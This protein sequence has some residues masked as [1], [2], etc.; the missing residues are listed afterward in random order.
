MKI[1]YVFLSMLA[2]GMLAACSN[3]EVAEGSNTT[4]LGGGEAYVKVRIAMSDGAASRA[5]SGG[6]DNGSTEERQIK[7][8]RF[9]FFNDENNLVTWGEDVGTTTV[10]PTTPDQNVEGL[11]EAVV[12]LILDE[13][14]EMP[15]KVVAYVNGA[16]TVAVGTTF[17]TGV[18]SLET[19]TIGNT[20]DGFVMTSSTYWNNGE[21]IATPVAPGDFY[22]TA[23]MA[24]TAENP[25]TIYVERLAAKVKVNEA[26]SLSDNIEDLQ[27]S[28]GNVLKFNL[29]GYALTGL[30][31]TEYYLKHLQDWSALSWTWNNSTDHRS[32]GLKTRI[33]SLCRMIKDW[34]LFLTK[35]LLKITKVF[36]IVWRIRLLLICMIRTISKLAP[37]YWLLVHTLLLIQAEKVL[38]MQ[39]EH[40]ICM[41]EKFI[42]RQA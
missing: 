27:D 16:P 39:M 19:N 42:P 33:I 7:S 35:K 29:V 3:D 13:G 23:E 5:T 10:T 14:D 24:T 41:V 36:N 30:N 21:Q 6:Y 40:S 26:T 15:T 31:T 1:K 18:R 9:A 4:N 11:A 28:E 38:P 2:C 17:S 32:F 8:I 22:E 37:V 12:A 25:V 34:I 20:T